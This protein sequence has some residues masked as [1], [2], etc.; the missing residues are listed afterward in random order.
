MG[1]IYKVFAKE[2]F[3]VRYEKLIR[4]LFI[5]LIV[6]WGL[7]LSGFRVQ[8]SPFVLY[9]MVGTFTAGVMWQALSSESIVTN[10]KN[11]YMLPFRERDLTFAYV[12][13]LG[14]HT[15]FTKTAGLMA[16]VLGAASL[17]GLEITGCIFCGVNAVLMTA[18]VYLWKRK[19]FAIM[20]GEDA[21]SFYP[22]RRSDFCGRRVKGSGRFLVW[23]YL[24][25]YLI[26]HKNYLVN[27]IAMWGIACL[28]PAFLG[29]IGDL[30]V[31]PVGFAVLSLNTPICI[32][33]SVD[34]GMERAIRSLPGQKKAFCV[35]YCLFIFLCHMIAEMIFL[36]SWNII[37]GRLRTGGMIMAILLSVFFALMSSAASVLLEWFYP[38][39]DW[40]IESDLWHHPRKY[41]VPIA[42]LLLAGAVSLLL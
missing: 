40:K 12:S 9:L 16:V 25:R 7:Y 8:I 35:P 19:L 41:I 3:G 22:G 13:A 37:V 1:K 5:F 32:L 36:C 28:L 24:L 34:P 39:R 38:V 33:L 17:S 31:I 20:A 11:M 23:H 42:M 29:G 27:T 2:L 18:L 10:M 6:F 15:L 21:Y 26:T 4:P 14:C 30:S